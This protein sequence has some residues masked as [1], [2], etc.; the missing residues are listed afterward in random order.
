MSEPPAA[1]RGRFAFP[2]WRAA[3]ECLVPR[4]ARQ[5]QRDRTAFA[6]GAVDRREQLD[7][8][9]AVLASDERRTALPDR[10]QEVGDLHGMVVGRC[11]DAGEARAVLGL[12][13]GQQMFLAG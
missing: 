5:R 2:V 8:R 6:A 9:P 10:P 4:L 12:E 3:L 7:D 13:L 1:S 11:V